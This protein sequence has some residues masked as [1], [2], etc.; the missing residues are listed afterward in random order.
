M[1][2]CRRRHVAS[3]PGECGRLE[4]QVAKRS[5]QVAVL[6][7]RVSQLTDQLAVSNLE[8]EALSYSVAHDLR[9]PLRAVSG[10]AEILGSEHSTE[11]SAPG[12]RHLA[13]VREGAAKMS[14]LIGHLL[15]YSRLSSADLHRRPVE[16]AAIVERV[17]AS[18]MAEA[19]KRVVRVSIGALPACSADPILLEQVLLNLLSNAWKF[20]GGRE[21]AIVEVGAVPADPAGIVYYVR[22]NGV[23]FDPARV[24]KL[25]GVFQRA[26][27]EDEFPGT[28]VGLAIVRRVISRHGGRVWAESTPGQG[29]CF[30]FTIPGTN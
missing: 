23:G 27:R 17:A 5:S 21:I 22:D 19:P 6:E 7:A 1:A 26:H 11:L 8:L 28:G 3:E 12:V 25:F 14:E 18:L 2:P 4:F 24:E 16:P 9:A 15:E 29:A 30:Y 20:T 13:H 10:F